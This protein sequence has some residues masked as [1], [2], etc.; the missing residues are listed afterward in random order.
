LRKRY[1]PFN[2]NWHGLCKKQDTNNKSNQIERFFLKNKILELSMKIL[3]KGFT[4]IEL[5][6]VIAI[7]GILAST[8]LP[9][10][11]EYIVNSQVATVFSSIT[12]MQ[13]AVETAVAR[14]GEA[15]L[16]GADAIACTNTTPANCMTRRYGLRAAPDASV[17]DGLSAVS[18]VTGTAISAATTTC[19]GFTLVPPTVAVATP[20]SKIRLTFDQTIDN[21]IGGNLDLNVIVGANGQGVSWLATAD[22]TAVNTLGAGTDLAGVACKWIHDNINSDFAS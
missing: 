11:R 22:G 5:M 7:I 20:G 9:A 3:Q 17:I 21:D 6:I 18:F 12:P 16:T 1:R 8:A 14:N 4:L 19:A 2:I 13:R 10:Y 15:W